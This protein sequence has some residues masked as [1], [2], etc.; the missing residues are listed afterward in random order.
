MYAVPVDVVKAPASVLLLVPVTFLT[1]EDPFMVTAGFSLEAWGFALLLVS[2]LYPAKP[3]PAPSRAGRAMVRLGQLSYAFYL[4]QKLPSLVAGDALKAMYAQ[5][6]GLN[7]PYALI[8]VLTFGATLTAAFVTTRL[9]EIPVLRWRECH[10][11]GRGSA[12]AGRAERCNSERAIHKAPRQWSS[13]IQL[14]R[15]RSFMA[16][17]NFYFR[18]KTGEGVEPDLAANE[19]A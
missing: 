6:R 14:R 10:F 15:R 8:V 13:A 11:S 7:I 4:W 16:G 9:I 2:V 19:R 12:I 5:A 3:A 1:R 18:T 17:L